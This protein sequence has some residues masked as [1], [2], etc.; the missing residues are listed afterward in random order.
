ME[1][2]GDTPVTTPVPLTVAMP[3]LTL[4]HAPPA[5]ASV[6]LVVDKL[7]KASVPVIA[8]GWTFTVTVAVATQL[9]I[10]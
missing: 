9:P 4:V 8:A 5:V 1:L 3:G 2:P 7:Q 10:A 6:R